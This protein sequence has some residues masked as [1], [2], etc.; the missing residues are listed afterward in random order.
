MDPE[1]SALD[2]IR[3]AGWRTAGTGLASDR[4]QAARTDLDRVPMTA[5]TVGAR[6]DELDQSRNTKA[7]PHR[8]LRPLDGPADGNGDVLNEHVLTI[9]STG[10]THHGTTPPR[11]RQ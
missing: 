11:S 5:R 1:P 10:T 7:L 8:W 3:L 6:D 4:R 9:P 2:A